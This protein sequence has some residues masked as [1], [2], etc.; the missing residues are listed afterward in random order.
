MYARQTTIEIDPARLDEVIADLEENDV[1]E[2]KKL[3]GFR[4]FLTLVD[5]KSG[6]LVGISFWATDDQMKNSEAVVAG[7]RERAARTGGAETEPLPER[8]EVALDV[9]VPRAKR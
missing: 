9:F 6:K 4:G 8:L 2:F 5:R 7:A 3:D 1:P